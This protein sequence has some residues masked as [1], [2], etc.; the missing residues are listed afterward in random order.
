M[1]AILLVGADEVT[2]SKLLL[3]GL[4]ATLLSSHLN[5]GRF[6]FFLFSITDLDFLPKTNKKKDPPPISNKYLL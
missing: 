4:K 6:F 1:Q 2:Q 3:E 5:T